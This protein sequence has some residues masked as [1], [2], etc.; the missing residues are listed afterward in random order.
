VNIALAIDQRYQYDRVANA[1]TFS[2]ERSDP[3]GTGYFLTRNHGV[4]AF[5]AVH[6]ITARAG[7]EID[8]WN[9]VAGELREEK[10][11][12]RAGKL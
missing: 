1:L 8:A 6:E 2:V 3:R 9:G 7:T 5:N 10:S 4:C 12:I 11:A